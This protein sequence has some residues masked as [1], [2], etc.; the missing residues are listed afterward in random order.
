MGARDKKDSDG[1]EC[2][3]GNSVARIAATSGGFTFLPRLGA[4]KEKALAA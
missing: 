3:K 4:A 2:D 1:R